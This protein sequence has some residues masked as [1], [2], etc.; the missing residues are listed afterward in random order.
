MDHMFNFNEELFWGKKSKEEREIKSKTKEF[1]L[2]VKSKLGIVLHDPTYYKNTNMYVYDILGYDDPNFGTKSVSNLHYAIS[3]QPGVTIVTLY[4][5]NRISNKL[6]QKKF[7]SFD[8]AIEFI[9]N[10]VTPSD[11]DKYLLT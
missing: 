8:N 5:H 9:T 3:V 4:V 10:K 7:S 11:I 6:L 1:A 2:I